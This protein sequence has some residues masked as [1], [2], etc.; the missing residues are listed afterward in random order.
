M[1]GSVKI[2]TF[3]LDTIFPLFIWLDSSCQALSKSPWIVQNG[4]IFIKLCSVVVPNSIL[5]TIDLKT[6]L[7]R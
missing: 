7:L 2:C 5:L 4:R 6:L 1:T 3:W